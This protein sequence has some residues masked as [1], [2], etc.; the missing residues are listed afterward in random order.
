L[1][2]RGKP[3]AASDAVGPIRFDA[4]SGLEGFLDRLDAAATRGWAYAKENPRQPVILA[5][6]DGERFLTTLTANVERPELPIDCGFTTRTPQ[7]LRDGEVHLLDIRIAGTAISALP[8]PVRTR[9][10]KALLGEGPLRRPEPR[11]A[12]EVESDLGQ[13]A[14]AAAPL[15]ET[16]CESATPAESSYSAAAQS[17]EASA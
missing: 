4:A 15:V 12:T 14:T 7:T 6:Y 13:E 1:F 8:Q 16:I 11:I 2:S 3:A 10:A 9:F 17:P 5:L